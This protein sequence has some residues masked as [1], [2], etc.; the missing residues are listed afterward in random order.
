[1]HTGISLPTLVLQQ[2]SVVVGGDLQ[3]QKLV[4]VGFDQP[5]TTAHVC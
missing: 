3:P 1:M 2:Q 5:P 4:G